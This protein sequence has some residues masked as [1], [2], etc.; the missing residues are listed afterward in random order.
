M[1]QDYASPHRYFSSG[2]YFVGVLG[3][4][5]GNGDEPDFGVND[6]DVVID[7][8]VAEGK[9][10]VSVI[11]K[12]KKIYLIEGNREWCS[13]LEKTFAPYKDKVEIIN[14][15]LT[16]KNDCDSITLDDLIETRGIEKVD[17]IKMDISGYE[18]K[19]LR[20]SFK[21]MN[22]GLIDKMAVCV[23][24][25]AEDEINVSDLLDDCGYETYLPKG[26]MV[27]IS[28]G[29]FDNPPIVRKGVVRAWR[30]A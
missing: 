21:A 6:G 24:H 9:F 4:T 3:V 14:K 13:A 29:E 7:A 27:L 22:S 10:A 20:G 15:F 28:G 16:D 30:K 1:T 5:Y 18:M 8:G 26:Y 17:L 12:V 25:R 11:D 19:A 2:H 23:Y